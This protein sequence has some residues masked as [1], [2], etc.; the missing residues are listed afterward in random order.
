MISRFDSHPLTSAVA[1]GRQSAFQPTVSHQGCSTCHRMH[2]AS[3]FY[4][5]KDTPSGI[6][7]RCKPCMSFLEY[8]R[9]ERLQRMRE[10]VAPVTEKTCSSCSK[11]L[12]TDH[13]HESRS[14]KDGLRGRCRACRFRR[15]R[16][17]FQERKQHF[18]LHPRLTVHGK[19]HTCNSCKTVKPVSEYHVN[20]KS[21]NGLQYVCKECYH[22]YNVA[23][24]MPG[25]QL[26]A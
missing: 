1:L 8:I 25:F 15:Y 21:Y 17:Y 18:S 9:M 26:V 12:P 19:V 11:R 6:E 10:S 14:T 22:I 13:F 24:K 23:K 16:V 3:W 5:R 20:S 7:N 2:P 4:G